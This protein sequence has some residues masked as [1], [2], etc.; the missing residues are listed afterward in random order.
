VTAEWLERL[1]G[2]E[3][4]DWALLAAAPFV[5]SFLGVVIRRLPDGASI[6]RGRSRCEHC[7]A[8]L[9]VRDLIPL[10]SWLAIRGHCRHC[11]H[12]IGWF[13]P[14]V[15]LGAVLIAAISLLVD[16]GAPAWLDWVLGC[17]L[18]TLGW[19]DARRWLLPD[20]LTLPLVLAGLGAVAWLAPGE[21]TDRGVGAV[22]GFLGL[23]AVAWAYRRL[24]GREGLGGG[25]T[26]LFAAAGAW[27][28]ASGLPSVLLGAAVAA[29]IVAGGLVVA[30]L[31]LD[32]HSPIPFGPFLALAT[33]LVWL[34][35]PLAL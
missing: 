26:K 3:A 34:F 5:G 4:S 9:T 27:V 29:L 7:Q 6:V 17:W 2:I 16:R 28:G 14:G 33:W 13:Y 18:L 31:R 22:A 24:R 30:G 12:Y 15:E 21:L 20:L 11:G 1:T 25:D 32:R 35:G 10:A 8:V 19:I 23:S